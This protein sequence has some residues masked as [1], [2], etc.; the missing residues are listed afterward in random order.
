M[1]LESNARVILYLARF[2]L[3]DKIGFSATTAH[4]VRL[5]NGRSA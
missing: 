4:L 2:A 3:P 5:L 1:L